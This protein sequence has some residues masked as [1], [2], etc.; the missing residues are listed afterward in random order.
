MSSMQTLTG[1]VGGHILEDVTTIVGSPTSSCVSTEASECSS[2]SNRPRKKYE[3]VPEYMKTAPDYIDQRVRNRNAVKRFREKSK[4]KAKQL[5]E[6][7]VS[8]TALTKLYDNELIRINRSKQPL[9]IFI[10]VSTYYLQ[11]MSVVHVSSSSS[12]TKY[13]S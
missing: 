12:S 9:Y 6:E 4:T 7:K 8:L 5:E 3:C 11:V 1:G 10:F 13:F 2:S